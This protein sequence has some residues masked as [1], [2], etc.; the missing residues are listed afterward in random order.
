[1]FF[2]T[3]RNHF[4]YEAGSTGKKLVATEKGNLQSEM[5]NV[6]LMLQRGLSRTQPFIK[7]TENFPFGLVLPLDT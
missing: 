4:Y 2:T 6:R 1:M 3:L 5:A 7:S